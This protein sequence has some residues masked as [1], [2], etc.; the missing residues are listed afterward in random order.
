MY[1][2]KFMIA[3]S[4]CTHVWYLQYKEDNKYNCKTIK[5]EMKN[6]KKTIQIELIKKYFQYT[7][8]II[9]TMYTEIRM[10]LINPL[11]I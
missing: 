2:Y 1:L 8:N 9:I 3:A 10:Y 5:S 6:Y 11:H 7:C 4:T